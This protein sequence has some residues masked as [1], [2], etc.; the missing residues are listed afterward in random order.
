MTPDGGYRQQRDRRRAADSWT[1]TSRDSPTAQPK[2][3]DRVDTDEDVKAARTDQGGEQPQGGGDQQ[4]G[5]SRDEDD[6]DGRQQLGGAVDTVT[7][8]AA[9]RAGGDGGGGGEAELREDDV[10]QPVAGI[11]DVLDNYAFVRTS[12]YLRRARTTSTS[13]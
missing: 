11:L 9:E 13:R 4:G 7:A 1:L 2:K 3:A 6:G 12:G 10:V 8:G 5:Q